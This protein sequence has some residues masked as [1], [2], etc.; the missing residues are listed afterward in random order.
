MRPPASQLGLA[1]WLAGCWLPGWLAAGWLAG[2][3]ASNKAQAA[4]LAAQHPTSSWAAVYVA[5]RKQL[6]LARAAGL[7]YVAAGAVFLLECRLLLVS[8]GTGA[9]TT[10]IDAVCHFKPMSPCR[11]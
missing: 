3:L 1:G 7:Q 9:I 2:W 5:Q 8:A 6:A 11:M 10:A 4:W